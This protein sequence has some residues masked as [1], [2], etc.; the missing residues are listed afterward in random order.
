MR[1]FLLIKNSIYLIFLAFF[2]SLVFSLLLYGTIK[3]EKDITQKMIEISTFDVISIANNNASSIEKSLQ[4][5][6]RAYKNF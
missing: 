2:I 5:S 6:T 4:T 1:K 3:L